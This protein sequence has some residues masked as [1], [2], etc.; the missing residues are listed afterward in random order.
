MS[1]DSVF[2]FCKNPDFVPCFYFPYFYY[3]RSL[4]FYAIYLLIRSVQNE[5]IMEKTDLNLIQTEIAKALNQL[6]NKSLITEAAL[7]K[8]IRENTK[9]SGKQK[10]GL[11]LS[12]LETA[13]SFLQ[14]SEG[15]FFSVHCNSANDLFVKKEDSAKPLDASA[16]QRRLKSEKNI[17]ILTSADLNAKNDNHKPQK[18]KQ[19][20]RTERKS[21]YIYG[22]YSEE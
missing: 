21:L 7:A 15:I 11:C 17:T 2:W 10:A 20:K 18:K 22:D 8:R 12:D 4:D 5:E 14:D 16:R 3:I 6:K 13:I 1:F 19:Q 9:F